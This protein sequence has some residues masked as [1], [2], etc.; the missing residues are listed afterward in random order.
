LKEWIGNA[1]QKARSII[2]NPDSLFTEE[3]L[4]ELVQELISPFG[5]S[6]SFSC[7]PN[8]F[9]DKIGK[10][11][12]RWERVGVM[13][14]ECLEY[15]ESSKWRRVSGGTVIASRDHYQLVCA[16]AG[17]RRWAEKEGKMKEKKNEEEEDDENEWPGME[18]CGDADQ[19]LLKEEEKLKCH[20]MCTNGKQCQGLPN[21]ELVM[22]MITNV[23]G[24]IYCMRCWKRFLIQN[25]RLQATYISGPWKGCSVSPKE[26]GM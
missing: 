14:K 25:W 23:P 3:G 26:L 15:V 7:V 17:K 24:N 12:S 8:T 18:G 5:D 2:V 20:K 16:P 1:M 11:P 9:I 4:K 13:V 10:P 22:H 6:H 21:D 19:T